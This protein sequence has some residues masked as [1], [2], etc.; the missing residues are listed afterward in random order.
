MRVNKN[1]TRQTFKSEDGEI[2]RVHYDNRGEPYRQGVSLIFEERQDGSG[3]F[4]GVFLEGYEAKRL[5][6]VLLALYPVIKTEEG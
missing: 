5:R 4:T 6:D 1:T 3:A 2:L